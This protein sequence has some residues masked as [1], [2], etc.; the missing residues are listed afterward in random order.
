MTRLQGLSQNA[1]RPSPFPSISHQTEQLEAQ[2]ID[3]VTGP[4]L[5]AGQIVADIGRSYGVS[6]S[7]I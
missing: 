7:T 4:K 5:F 3:Y 1:A 2:P 6:H